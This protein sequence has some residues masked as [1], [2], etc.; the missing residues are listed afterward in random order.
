[1]MRANRLSYAL[2]GGASH[3]PTRTNMYTIYSIFKLWQLF[4]NTQKLAD[5]FFPPLSLSLFV[6]FFF[7]GFSVIAFAKLRT[8]QAATTAAASIQLW[9][10]WYFLRSFW[11]MFSVDEM[12]ETDKRIFD[13]HNTTRISV[14][15][16]L[17]I[18]TFVVFV[19]WF[20]VQFF[21][22]F[23]SPWICSLSPVLFQLFFRTILTVGAW[24][25]MPSL[26]FIVPFLGKIAERNRKKSVFV[27][28]CV[29][30]VF[31]FSCIWL[32]AEVWWMARRV[33]K[34]WPTDPQ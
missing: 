19:D 24:L 21:G 12:P 28:L 9:R 33:E 2:C 31:R 4:A 23:F 14:S 32:W 16:S 15:V 22:L 11:R 6:Y 1:M 18:F 29:H 34:G 3:M 13:W 26:S 7:S 5:Q 27:M 8:P 20:S 10:I 17:H 30:G 25:T